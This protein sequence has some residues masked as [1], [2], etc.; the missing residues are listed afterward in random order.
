[1]YV[2]EENYIEMKKIINYIISKH[3]ETHSYSQKDEL[4]SVGNLGLAKANKNYT[5]SVSAKF[6]TYAY[7]CIFNEISNYI[8]TEKKYTNDASFEFQ[9][10][11]GLFVAD[12]IGFEDSSIE[13]IEYLE[14][15]RRILSKL[16]TREREMI[17]MLYVEGLT[18]QRIAQKYGITQP[19]VHTIIQKTVSRMKIDYFRQV[20]R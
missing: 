11:E 5:Q 13:N 1:M 20:K 2:T 15:Q 6:T 9:V 16:P 19:R 4:F 17:Q 10:S 3:F 7:R 12:M 18:M 8:R 14:I